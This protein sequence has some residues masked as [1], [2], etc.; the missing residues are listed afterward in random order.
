MPGLEELFYHILLLFYIIL[1][2]NSLV[3]SSVIS[4]QQIVGGA[5]LLHIL[6]NIYNLTNC[7]FIA[8]ALR[9][10]YNLPIEIKTAFKRACFG[11]KL[12]LR[13]VRE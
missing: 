3:Y 4:K 5:L 10:L 12:L 9:M 11:D 1:S 2:K 13:K 6:I 8:T 7:S